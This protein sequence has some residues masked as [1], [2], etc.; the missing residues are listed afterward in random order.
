MGAGQFLR[1]FRRDYHLK[2]SSAH[3]KT[4]MERKE[5]AEEKRMKVHMQQI[6]QDRSPSK[7]YSHARLLSLVNE[8][9]YW[10]LIRLYAKNDLKCLCDAYDVVYRSNWNK[11]KLASNLANAI[12]SVESMP[13]HQVTSRYAIDNYSDIGE[14]YQRDRVPIMRIRRV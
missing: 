3:R 1:D 13:S 9:G 7:K 4:V 5:K 6:E 11:D 14:E 2:K 8:L 12:L 10:G